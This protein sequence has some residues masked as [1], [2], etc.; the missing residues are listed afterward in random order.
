MNEH[1]IPRIFILD[2]R[3]VLLD[4][5]DGVPVLAER[6]NEYDTWSPKRWPA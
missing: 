3:Q 5:I 1:E 4:W 2:D 6:R